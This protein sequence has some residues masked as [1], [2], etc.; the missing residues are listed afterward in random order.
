ML[1]K[2]KIQR[3]AFLISYTTGDKAAGAANQSVEWKP[4]MKISIWLIGRTL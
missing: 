2:I 4:E 1:Q 3:K